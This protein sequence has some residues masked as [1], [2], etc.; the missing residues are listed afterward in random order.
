[1]EEVREE[2]LKQLYKL[3]ETFMVNHEFSNHE[4]LTY[5]CSTL[6]NELLD[7]KYSKEEVQVTL[8]T[9]KEIYKKNSKKD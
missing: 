5:L 3:N 2:L 7:Q 4:V 1:M 8:K 6:L 9:I